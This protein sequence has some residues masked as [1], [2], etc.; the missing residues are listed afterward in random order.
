MRRKR[1]IPFEY[2]AGAT[3]A[4]LAELARDVWP[5][6]LE[7]LDESLRDTLEDV[8]KA[9]ARWARTYTVR[10]AGR[11]C[12][13]CFVFEK[14]DRREMS[15]TKTRHLAE[16]R[17]YTFAVGIGQLLRDLAEREDADGHGGKPMYMHVPEGD[18]RSRDWFVR[19][20]G[21][22]ETEWGLKCP[23]KEKA[24]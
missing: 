3:D 14:P 9:I 22:E 15:F 1:R 12:G 8:F 2:K 7:G 16:E 10:L 23:G 6:E 13:I 17:K 11:L 5:G 24:E 4:E 18:D 19:A 21:C 20:G